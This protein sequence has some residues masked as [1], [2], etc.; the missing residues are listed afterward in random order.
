M[1]LS[2]VISGYIASNQNKLAR[3]TSKEFFS[4]NIR[5]VNLEKTDKGYVASTTDPQLVIP[6][7]NQNVRN[8]YIGGGFTK[9]D[10]DKLN[11]VLVYFTDKKSQKGIQWQN[12]K[13]HVIH[14]P[15]KIK[16]GKIY[17]TLDKKV[18]DFR[19]D[20]TAVKDTQFPDITEISIN[21][22][23]QGSFS[24]GIFFTIILVFLL[25]G[26]V[27]ATLI[28]AGYVNKKKQPA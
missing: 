9:D 26:G 1:A 19:V 22:N 14:V 28:F 6:N 20:L 23:E 5:F 18:Y 24:V 15:T 21:P 13:E 8:F 17:F 27:L 12:D 11:T 3:Q 2:A 7:L 25:L 4:E 10:Y 16:N